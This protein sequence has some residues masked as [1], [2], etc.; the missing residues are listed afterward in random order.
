MR[1]R[2]FLI[3]VFTALFFL[4]VGCKTTKQVTVKGEPS[5]VAEKVC[6]IGHR[7]GAGL[8]PENTLAAFAGA[9]GLGVDA[10]E[11]DAHLTAD[12]AVVIYHDSVLKPEITRTPDGR[13]LE[14]KG[15][16]I[17]S[18]TLE[19]L[20][21]YDVG[22]LKPGTLYGLRYPRQKPVDGE[23]IP[24]LWEVITLTRKMGNN[25][26]GFWIEI[27]TSPLEPRLTPPPETV[28]DAVISLLREAGV[29]DRTV[30]Q[31]FDWRSL[32]HVDTIRVG[33]P[34][35]SPWTAGLDADQFGGSVPQVVHAAGGNYWCPRHN[36][37]G[38]KQIK[39]AHNLGLKVVVWT[40]NRRAPMRRLIDMGV[41]GIMTDRPDL[42]KEVIAEMDLR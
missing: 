29:A 24:T 17:Q 41:D 22:R 30:L 15:L 35:A 10:I 13:W 19:Q 5:H 32:V 42:L 37:V 39:E 38:P 31:S 21:S 12:G 8:L 6:V 16:A 23:R 36:Q 14:K 26:V 25:T 40:P 11:M 4:D 3:S 18:L 1:N 9:L 27:K 34:G 28:A 20:K 2:T 33:K 7:G